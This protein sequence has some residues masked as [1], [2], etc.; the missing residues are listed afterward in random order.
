MHISLLVT[1]RCKNDFPLY[2]ASNIFYLFH[3]SVVQLIWY[4]FTGLLNFPISRRQLKT[5]CWITPSCCESCFCVCKSFSSNSACNS[6]SS[7][8]FLAVYHV[9][10]LQHQNHHL[11]NAK[12]IVYMYLVME[13]G[14][15]KLLEVFIMI[16]QQFSSNESKKLMLS[17][18]AL[19]L[20]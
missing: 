19:C 16:Q 7:Y 4:P 11:W 6:T 18:N 5:V 1:I 15:H 2:Q 9:P 17:A 3:L 13:H 14:H 10:F 8:L 20:V 12:T